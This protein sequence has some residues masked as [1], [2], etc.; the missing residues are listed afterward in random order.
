MDALKY[1]NSE[2]GK[3]LALSMMDKEGVYT[4]GHSSKIKN[5][6]D[7]Y[8]PRRWMATT[9]KQPIKE[10]LQGKVFLRRTQWISSWRAFTKHL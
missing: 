10:G 8:S 6:G 2:M 9:F 7:E 4:Q 5:G 3:L 1:D